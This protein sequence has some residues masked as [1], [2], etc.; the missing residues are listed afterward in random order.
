MTKYTDT[1]TV[2]QTHSHAQTDTIRSI[3]TNYTDKQ[4]QTDIQKQTQYTLNND[5]LHE[6]SDSPADR[7]TQIDRH[8]TL[9]TDKLHRHKHGVAQNT[10]P[11]TTVPH[12]SQGSVNT[13]FRYE[14]TLNDKFT[15]LLLNLIVTY[16]NWQSYSA[17][18]LLVGRLEGHP[19]CKKN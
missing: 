15:N 9:H 6:L 14:R 10:G 3:P 2:I 4:T 8:N 17:L 16:E 5:K 18:T 7:Q 11:L 1:Q 12:I 13:H 19:A